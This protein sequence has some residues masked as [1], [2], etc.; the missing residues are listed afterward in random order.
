MVRY[1]LATGVVFLVILV[2]VGRTAMR[3]FRDFIVNLWPH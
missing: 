2:I 1:I 3:A